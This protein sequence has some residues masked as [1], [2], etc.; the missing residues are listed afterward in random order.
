MRTC[1]LRHRKR[2]IICVFGR[3]SILFVVVFGTSV[4]RLFHRIW[5]SLSVL[6]LYIVRVL[7]LLLRRN[8]G[9]GRL[10]CFVGSALSF[11]CV[12]VG[13]VALYLWGRGV[14]CLGSVVR[15]N[16]CVGS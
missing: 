10:S 14:P 13:S 3:Y 8:V 9:L 5:C 15:L 1:F 11:P 16:S 7:W 12:C 6:V 4:C 2:G